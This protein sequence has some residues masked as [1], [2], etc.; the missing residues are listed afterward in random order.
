MLSGARSAA[1][2]AWHL[3]TTHFAATGRQ[4]CSALAVQCTVL[5][6]SVAQMAA[7]F[8]RRAL[9]ESNRAAS[10]LGP[11]CSSYSGFCCSSRRLCCAQTLA[12]TLVQQ[13]CAVGRC[14]RRTSCAC[15]HRRDTLCTF[16]PSSYQPSAGRPSQRTPVRLQCLPTSCRRAAGTRQSIC[17]PHARA[18]QASRSNR[19]QCY[20]R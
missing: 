14:T 18:L 10:C 20:N 13:R 2:R 11:N 16:R 15:A 9:G 8:C 7:S 6:C 5:Q 17:R 4:S 12:C 1:A 3:P 19:T